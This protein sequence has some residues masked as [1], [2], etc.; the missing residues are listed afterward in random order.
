M[1]DASSDYGVITGQ[2]IEVMV[3]CGLAAGGDTKKRAEDVA[4]A[5]KIIYKAV[6]DP[7]D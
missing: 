7:T 4:T 6:R 5:F 1:A 2:I 3:E